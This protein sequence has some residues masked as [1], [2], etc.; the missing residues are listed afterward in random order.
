MSDQWEEWDR[1]ERAR[2]WQNTVLVRPGPFFRIECTQAYP[3]IGE[4]PKARRLVKRAVW[5]SRV[6]QRLSLRN[7]VRQMRRIMRLE[8]PRSEARN[9]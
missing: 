1:R 2:L 8:I 7:K 9:D 5:A 3:L 6:Y 4:V